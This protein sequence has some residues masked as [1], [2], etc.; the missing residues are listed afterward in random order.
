MYIYNINNNKKELVM[1][2]NQTAILEFVCTAVTDARASLEE[3]IDDTDWSEKEDQ[4]DILLGMLDNLQAVESQFDA[5]KDE[6]ELYQ[7]ILGGK[8]ISK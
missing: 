1:N 7:M 2:K 4:E 5:Y 8:K 6:W 3:L